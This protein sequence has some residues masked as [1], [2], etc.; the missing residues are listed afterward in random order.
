MVLR[1][2][3]NIATI[4]AP[5]LTGALVAASGYGAM[6]TAAAV[7]AVVGMIAMI[8]VK[9]GKRIIKPIISVKQSS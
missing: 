2:F 6:F 5:T 1:T 8:F 4:V 7:A 9:P 3:T